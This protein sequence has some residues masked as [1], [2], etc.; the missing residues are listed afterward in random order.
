MDQ[1]IYI[2]LLITCVVL[3]LGMFFLIRYIGEKNAER[4]PLEQK[5][6]LLTGSTNTSR[7]ELS[8][9]WD[10]AL[11]CFCLILSIILFYRL[12]EPSER[13]LLFVLLLVTAL[14][15]LWSFIK[16]LKNAKT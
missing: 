3:G 8:P 7:K 13:W 6:L 4:H 2:W 1:S 11:T 9:W 12:P 14:R 10:L 16:E 5:R 15:S